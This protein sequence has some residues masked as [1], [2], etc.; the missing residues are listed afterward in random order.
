MRKHNIY[1]WLYKTT[2]LVNSLKTSNLKVET[3][4][5]I[6]IFNQNQFCIANS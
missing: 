4:F 3:K 6:E 5:K 2:V 1:T